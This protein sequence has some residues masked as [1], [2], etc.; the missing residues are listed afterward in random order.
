[1]AKHRCA[2]YLR[3]STSD[4]GQTVENQRRDLMTLAEQR[5]WEIVQSYED[6]ASGAKGR[7]KRP[8]FDQML[9]DAVKG[10]FNTLLVW[11][12]DRLGRSLGNLITNLEELHRSGV[13]LVI[14]KEA[15]DTTSPAGKA[16]FGMLG[17]FAE[18]ER[19]MIQAR[20][21]AGMN[22]A[23]IEQQK[24][25]Q[26]GIERLHADGRVK[27]PIGRPTLSKAQHK[28]VVRALEEGLGQ[29]ATALLT[30]VSTTKIREIQNALGL[31]KPDPSTAAQ[32]KDQTGC[33]FAALT[34]LE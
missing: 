14:H 30:G 2:F 28:E 21:R 29:R 31:N 5:G 8:G 20:V 26:R 12:V 23:Q 3:V 6:Y 22:R 10:R 34:C 13:E 4:K 11:S 7:D 18:F 25:Q 1:M 16:L 33:A 15:I 17:V 27:K 24:A 32:S 19:S 9:K